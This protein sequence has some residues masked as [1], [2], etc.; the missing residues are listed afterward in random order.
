V[1]VQTPDVVAF[2]TYDP[3]KN[4]RMDVLVQGLRAHGLDVVVR[5]VPIGFDSKRR[6][7]MLRRPWLLVF[8][9]ARLIVIWTKLWRVSRDVRDAPVVVI[10]W[11]AHLDIHL[12][13]RRFKR[14]TVVFD[15]L[16]SMAETSGDRDAGEGFVLRVLERL[17]RSAL[18]V[19]DVVVVDTDEHLAGVP[20]DFRAKAVEV[21]VG[22][23]NEW[24]HT[25]AH[26]EDGRLRVVFFGLYTPLQGAPV[27]GRALG[28]LTGTIE[29]TMVGDGQ[30]FDATLRAARNA[31]NVHWIKWLSADDLRGCVASND[32][33]L[34]IF[35]TNPKARLVVPNK[36]Y[37][38]A[39]AGCAIVTSDTP[40]QRRAFGDA[41]IYVP[42]GDAA[43][44]AEALH[45]L[46]ADPERAFEM[47]VAAYRRADE[48]FRPRD[49]TSD[50]AGRLLARTY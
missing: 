3:S 42:S 19:A 10:G 43:A 21:A 1:N 15:H 40:P 6:S 26:R 37:Q 20:D 34:G 44:L 31:P 28:E 24:F 41:A 23:S 7:A 14:A 33:C 25:P 12:A 39:A 2:G 22:A 5:C 11:L 16:T 32:V 18:T 46:A 9:V 47:R 29:V 45:K 27:I 4:P 36:I 49:V 48:R 8:F 13:K 17:D 35:G 38:G 50:L 30:D